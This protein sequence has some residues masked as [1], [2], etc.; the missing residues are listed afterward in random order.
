MNWC[1]WRKKKYTTALRNA[2]E[3][4]FPRQKWKF[5]ILNVA[6]QSKT[7][8]NVKKTN[9]EK[10]R[11]VYI[12]TRKCRFQHLISSNPCEQYQNPWGII[13]LST[14]KN[15]LTE[16]VDRIKTNFFLQICANKI[17]GCLFFLIFVVADVKLVFIEL[18][19]LVSV[20]HFTHS[21]YLHSKF[22][23]YR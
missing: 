22:D 14:E 23:S 12:L 8:R 11:H 5:F 3:W 1:R 10:C 2:F 4:Y 7:K 17:N 20:L 18:F 6:M 9:T 13:L 16:T 21:K 15:G 19:N